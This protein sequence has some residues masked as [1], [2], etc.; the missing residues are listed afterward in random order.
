MS[1]IINTEMTKEMQ[2]EINGSESLVAQGQSQPLQPKTMW[3]DSGLLNKAWKSAQFL[4]KTDFVPQQFKKPENCLIA[5]D[6]ANRTGMSPLAVMQ[7]LYVVQGKPSWSGQMCIAL[8]NGC[9]RFTPLEFIED[10]DVADGTY[11]CVAVAERKDNHKLYY[12]DKVTLQMAKDEGWLNKNGSK[13]KTMPVQM[14]RYRAGAFFARAHCPEL[15]IGL[16][17]ADELADVYGN[18]PKATTVTKITLE[19][20]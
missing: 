15:L 2:P 1:D 20:I 18:E 10:G 14:A 6:I 3:N 7:N 13:W 17:L 5:L 16:P 9:G 4:S 11:G 8:I 12:S 19:D